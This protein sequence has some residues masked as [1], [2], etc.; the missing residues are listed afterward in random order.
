M[1]GLLRKGM[2]LDQIKKLND[3]LQIIE[4]EADRLILELYQDAYTN[5]SDPIRYLVKKDLFEIIEKAIDRCR[6][7]GNVI[8]HIVLK[9]S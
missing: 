2:D 1:V 9:N 6:D 7:A 5:E 4:S 8:Y 3:Q